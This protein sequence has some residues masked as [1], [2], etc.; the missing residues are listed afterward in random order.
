MW[1]WV[2]PN[3]WRK[4][5]CMP[6]AIIDL[7]YYILNYNPSTILSLCSPS[8]WPHATG[9]KYHNCLCCLLERHFWLISWI[10]ACL[11]ILC[12]C[13]LVKK[14]KLCLHLMIFFTQI[15]RVYIWG[16]TNVPNHHFIPPKKCWKPIFEYFKIID[17]LHPCPWSSQAVFLPVYV[18]TLL[19]FLYGVILGLIQFD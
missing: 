12:C 16:L 3:L 17:C 5:F 7:I 6:V 10:T 2:K 15:H 1:T 8:A 4:R 19:H 18:D 13:V 14:H 9:H 11:H